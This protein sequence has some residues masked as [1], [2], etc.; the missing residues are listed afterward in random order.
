MKLGIRTLLY[1]ERL[2]VLTA[3]DD[4]RT[5]YVTEDCLTG[6]LRPVVLRLF[7]RAMERG[8]L[9]CALGLKKAAERG[10]GEAIERKEER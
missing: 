3:I 2:Q 9:D 1:A 7:G 6:W 10:L 8:F 5:H 4:R